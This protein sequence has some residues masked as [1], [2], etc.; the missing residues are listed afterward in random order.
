MVASHVLISSAAVLIFLISTNCQP[1]LKKR[2]FKVALQKNYT[3]TTNYTGNNT[4]IV[5]F[6]AQKQKQVA[7]NHGSGNLCHTTFNKRFYFNIWIMS[8]L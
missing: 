3:P 7:Y 8:L 5:S 1:V 6:M 2:Q 4:P